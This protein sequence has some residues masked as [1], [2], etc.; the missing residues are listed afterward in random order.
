MST[1][2]DSQQNQKTTD[3]GEFYDI[4]TPPN[5]H[6]Y[7]SSQDPTGAKKA[8]GIEAAKKA[9][10]EKTEAIKTVPAKKTLNDLTSDVTGMVFYGIGG[11]ALIFLAV[12]ITLM[13]MGLRRKAAP[14]AMGIA[15]LAALAWLR[16]A[17]S[18]NFFQ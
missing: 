13:L 1:K 16:Y 7:R 17:Y 9:S 18:Q 6:Y 11:S 8:K 15:G 2:E 3:Y 4:K 14:I 12:A 10:K 5:N